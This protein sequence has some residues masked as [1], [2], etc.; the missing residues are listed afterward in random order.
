[1]FEVSIELYWSAQ[2]DGIFEN[3]TTALWWQKF[4]LKDISIS[5]LFEELLSWNLE[6]KLNTPKYII[7][8]YFG[9]IVA[10]L[11]CCELRADP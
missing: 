2:H 1:M 11:N 7:S 6:S 3:G 10:I 8:N 9:A 4:E 5:E